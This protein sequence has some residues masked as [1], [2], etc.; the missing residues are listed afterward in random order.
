MQNPETPAAFFWRRLHSFTGLVLV[1][2]IIGHLLTNSQA[3]LYL[4]DDGAGFIHDVN[5]I[6][7]LPY[8]PVLEF[9]VIFLPFLIHGLWGIKYLWT[10]KS[11]SWPTDGSAPALPQYARNQCFT[12]QRITS[13]ILLVGVILHV[14]QMRFNEYPTPAKLG[15]HTYYVSNVSFDDGLYTLGA[16]LNFML[17]SETQIAHEKQSLAQ[18]KYFENPSTPQELIANQWVEQKKHWIEALESKPVR[19]GQV[20]VLSPD[21]GTAELLLVRNTFKN[22]LMMGLYTGFVVAAV[23]HAFNGLWTFLIT[24]GLLLTERSQRYMKW[25]SVFLM[26][27]FGSLS[28]SAI[29]LTYLINLRH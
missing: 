16:R 12:W 14:I 17:L 23:F 6:H 9:L 15:D 19:D 25:L 26:I 8:L 13:W 2:F 5:W 20:T 29:W 7:S 11:N 24:W 27:L 22:P 10:S 3:A 18:A 1:L 21:F 4:G 28:I